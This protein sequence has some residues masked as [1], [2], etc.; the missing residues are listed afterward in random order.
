MK[1][2]VPSA[3]WISKEPGPRFVLL[4]GMTMAPVFWR[5]FTPDKLLSGMSAAY[6]LPGHYPWTLSDEER[7]GL[8]TDMIVD[9]YAEV[10]ERDF[11]GNPVTL[12]GHSTGAHL[13]LLVAARRPDL[14]DGVI[15]AGGF[16]CGRFEG[17]ES[18]ATRILMMPFLG[19]AIFMKLF[20]RWISTPDN[21]RMGAARCVGDRAC[22]WETEVTLESM[23]NVRRQLLLSNPLDIVAM[24][25]W[26]RHQSI[27]KSLPKI[28]RPV[29]NVI[30]LK[31]YVV[32]AVHQLN[33]SRQLPNVQTVLLPNSGHLP[34]VEQHAYFNRVVNAF[35]EMNGLKSLPGAAASFALPAQNAQ[36]R[37]AR[38]QPVH[39]PDLDVPEDLRAIAGR[40]VSGDKINTSIRP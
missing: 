16:G 5:S 25:T 28:T 9:A 18:I 8:C 37:V 24:A 19:P 22:P 27:M 11:G 21:F 23:E 13:C 30:G 12:V 10:I 17:Q 39:V 31:D 3:E 40:L 6:P 26:L 33:V 20:S 38:E 36:A 2:S 14:V 32:P 29:L 15:L 1:L 7:A 35:V 34:M 4:H